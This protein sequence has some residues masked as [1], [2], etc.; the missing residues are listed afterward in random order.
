VH[1]VS[2]LKSIV[3]RTT[4]RSLQTKLMS[5]PMPQKTFSVAPAQEVEPNPGDE[6]TAQVRVVSADVFLILEELD[7]NDRLLCVLEFLARRVDDRV[8]VSLR[9]AERRTR[10][11]VERLGV[12][13]L[14]RRESH[15][16]TTVRQE[17]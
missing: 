7:G 2:Q 10:A 4:G 14:R 8:A 16:H 5:S 3:I 11:W 9:E 13:T 12:D 1:G 15:Q 6:L 17:R